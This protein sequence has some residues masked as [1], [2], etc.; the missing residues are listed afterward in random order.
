MTLSALMV[1]VAAPMP[2]PA[3]G[4]PG[5]VWPPPSI[6]YN[7][8]SAPFAHRYLMRWTSVPIGVSV[9]WSLQPLRVA[10]AVVT[11]GTG[12]AP[13]RDGGSEMSVDP[14]GRGTPWYGLLRSAVPWNTTSG[15]G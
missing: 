12:G 14:S 11:A 3:F 7:S 9:V 5:H 4:T 13:L 10:H 1:M 8:T 2:M 6:L 15:T